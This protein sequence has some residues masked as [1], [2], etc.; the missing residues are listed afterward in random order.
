M[1]HVPPL[2]CVPRGGGS[3]VGRAPGCGPGGRG[4]ESRSPP[5]HF[6]QGSTSAEAGILGA[7]MRSP[8]SVIRISSLFAVAVVAGYLWRDALQGPD[9]V[10]RG[11]PPKGLAERGDPPVIYLPAIKPPPAEQTR[12]TAPNTSPGPGSE[13]TPVAPVTP[14]TSGPGSPST[15]APSAPRPRPPAPTAT[16]KPKPAPTPRPK[17]TPTPAPT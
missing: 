1:P 3:S 14:G 4:F 16:P 12:P 8:W 13:G 5:L 15:P 2:S 11:F 17:P 9:A 6:W 7:A 10:G